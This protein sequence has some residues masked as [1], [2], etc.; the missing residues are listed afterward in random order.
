MRRLAI[1]LTLTMFGLVSAPPAA[2]ACQMTPIH[3]FDPPVAPYLSSI[4]LATDCY[5]TGPPGNPMGG[6]VVF[7]LEYHSVNP[8]T[9]SVPPQT[10]LPPLGPYPDVGIV[11]CSDWL[12]GPGG[13]RL[14]S[15]WIISH[16]CEYQPIHR[17]G[18]A[19]LPN[20]DWIVITCETQ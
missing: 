13:C 16:T 17:T 20:G 19:Y 1:L 4:H 18:P 12:Y 15:T 9:A 5:G 11:H 14:A 10:P 7:T 8:Q 3:T 6:S 2:A